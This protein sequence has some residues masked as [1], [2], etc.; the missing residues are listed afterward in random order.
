MPIHENTPEFQLDGGTLTVILNGDIDHHSS[1]SVRARI[2]SEIFLT[3]PRS[4][5]LDLSRVDFM[6]SSGLGLI[7]G[8]YTKAGE[9]GCD[10]LL[11]NPNEKVKKILDLAGVERLIGMIPAED[12]IDMLLTN[13]SDT[14]VQ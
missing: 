14:E 5:I 12:D 11:K 1:K 4:I 10:F 3:R 7:L 2:D 8:R 13:E 6:D 9:L